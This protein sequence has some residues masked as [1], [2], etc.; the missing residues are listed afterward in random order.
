MKCQI[1]DNRSLVFY[2][3]ANIWLIVIQFVKYDA[4]ASI[5]LYTDDIPTEFMIGRVDWR[6]ILGSKV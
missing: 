1:V 5:E 2:F 4:V 6:V 3:N